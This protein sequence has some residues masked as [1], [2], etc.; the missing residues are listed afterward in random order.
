MSEQTEIKS[1]NE[2]ASPHLEPVVM[3][4]C[5]FCGSSNIREDQ[6]MFCDDD[7]E[8][9]GIECIDCDA[10]NRREHWNKRSC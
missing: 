9:S 8:H 2:A 3:L 6:A 7:G 4:P 5:P 1:S 10:I